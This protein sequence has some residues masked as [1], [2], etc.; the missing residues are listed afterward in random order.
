MADTQPTRQETLAR[1]VRALGGE[2]DTQRAL[3]ALHAAGYEVP[4]LTAG[5]KEARRV[6]RHLAADGL[7]VKTDPDRAVYQRAQDQ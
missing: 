3:T 7:L 4:D 5:E 6:L 2:W 1:S